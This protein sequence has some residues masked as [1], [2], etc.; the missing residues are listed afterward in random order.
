MSTAATIASNP[1]LIK[2]GE[3]LTLGLF[4][5]YGKM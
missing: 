3:N 5:M 2:T 4:N 1:D